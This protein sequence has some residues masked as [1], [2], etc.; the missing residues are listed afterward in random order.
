MKTFVINV[1]VMI[2]ICVSAIAQENHMSYLDNGVIRIGVN[3]D[4][5]GAI[6]YLAD[7][8]TKKN[9]INSHD[10]GRQIQM[11]FYSGPVP[12]MPNGKQPSKTWAGLGWNPIQSGDYA[13]NRSKVLAHSNADQELYVKCVPM[14]W[15]LDNEPGEC[16]FETWI[17]LDSNRV[18]VRSRLNNLRKDKTQYPGRSQELPAIYTNGPWYRLMTYDGDIPFTDGKLRQIKK[19]WSSAKDLEHGSPWEHWLAT[20]NWAALVNDDLFGIGIWK[21]GTY[22][23]VG[24]FFGKPGSG[25]PKDGPTGYISPLEREILDFDIVYTYDYTLIVGK[26]DEIRQYVYDQAKRKPLESRPD[27][28]FEQNRQHWVY[29]N[30]VDTGL[31]IKGGLHVKLEQ[32]DPQLIGPAEFWQAS[33]MPVLYIRAALVNKQG[34]SK[35]QLFWKT[36]SDPHFENKKSISFKMKNDG[37]FYTY[38]I[39]LA[40][41]REYKGAIVGLRFDPV[42]AGQ[43]GDYVKIESI[44]WRE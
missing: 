6:T 38:K 8:K 35:A 40:A 17:K 9:M 20:E 23:F 43:Q 13:G 25:G 15:P 14:Q 32:N 34:N 18:L 2:T 36:F 44:S 33:Q 37:N 10:W 16:T 12:F 22:N 31:P 26:L 7:V 4:I 24:G 11:S 39:N 27:Y 5:G 28:R 30:V 1:L 21:P 41:N 42:S 19:T 3:L 29:R